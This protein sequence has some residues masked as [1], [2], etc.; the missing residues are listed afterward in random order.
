VLHALNPRDALGKEES[1]AD[2][3][4]IRTEAQRLD[5]VGAPTDTSIDVDLELALL[6][7]PVGISCSELLGV[8]E[9]VFGYA[10]WS[11]ELGSE[12]LRRVLPDLKKDVK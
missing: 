1:P 2:T 12:E 3:H 9:Q 8:F 6:L 10:C 7:L 5:H 11:A 4:G